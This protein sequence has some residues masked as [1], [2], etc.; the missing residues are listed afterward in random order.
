ML[1]GPLHIG[2]IRDGTKKIVWDGF[3]IERCYEGCLLISLEWVCITYLK[4]DCY[5]KRNEVDNE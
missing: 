4:G 3:L 2:F 5:L 1:I